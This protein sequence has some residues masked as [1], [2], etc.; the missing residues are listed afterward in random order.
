M[1]MLPLVRECLAAAIGFAADDGCTAAA[2]QRI[3][4]LFARP[5]RTS[6]DFELHVTV[7]DVPAARPADRPC[8]PQSGADGVVRRPE[9]RHAGLLMFCSWRRPPPTLGEDTIGG[10]QDGRSLDSLQRSAATARVRTGSLAEPLHPTQ[11]A[12]APHIR[13]ALCELPRLVADIV[14]VLLRDVPNLDIAARAGGITDCLNR[15]RAPV[16]VVVCSVAES[17]LIPAWRA[18][19]GRRALPAILNLDADSS[20]G[21]LYAVYPVQRKLEDITA[22]SLLQAVHDH[23]RAANQ[24]RS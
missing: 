1:M 19:L 8:P 9:R 12:P 4:A 10:S 20:R 23:M 6:G 13:I 2:S 22:D 3:S 5:A 15:E 21:D 7:C 18:A 24:G 11:D 17:D 16:D 14:T